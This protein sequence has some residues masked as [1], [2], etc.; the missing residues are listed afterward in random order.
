MGWRGRHLIFQAGPVPRVTPSSCWWLVMGLC[1]LCP[2]PRRQQ[3]L[4]ASWFPGQVLPSGLE[5]GPPFSVL[6]GIRVFCCRAPFLWGRS[7][8]M[9]SGQ[10]LKPASVP[11][12]L[13]R[14]PTAE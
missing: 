8:G 13:G 10:L 12:Q 1:A 5:G 4:Q 2:A 7:G 6:P 3:R 14:S 9:P 11:D